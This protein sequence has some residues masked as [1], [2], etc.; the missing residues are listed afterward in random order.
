MTMSPATTGIVR[1]VGV[2]VPYADTGVGIGLKILRCDPA[3]G[4]WVIQNRFD[5][6]V[7]LPRHK[8]T[9]T[10]EGFT[11]T[12]R[13]HYLEYDFWSE[14]GSYIHEPAGSVHTLDV[15]AENSGPT[16]VLF[17][18][19]GA[20]LDLDDDDSVVTVNDGPGTLEAYY[21]LLDAA[22]V[23]RPTTVIG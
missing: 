14:A 19:E 2:D 11:I 21:A 6:G 3:A 1:H 20:L 18:I 22:G 23:A 12:G 4:V 10:V 7:R 8:H 16:E 15:P 5:P 13:W 9:G 17:V